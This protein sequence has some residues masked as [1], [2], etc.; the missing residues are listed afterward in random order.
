MK[1]EKEKIANKDT[2]IARLAKHIP[3]EAKLVKIIIREIKNARQK[4]RTRL[5]INEKQ[6]Q[7]HLYELIKK[8]EKSQISSL[9]NKFLAEIKIS[10]QKGEKVVLQGIFSAQVCRT[11]ARKVKN[12]QTGQPMIVPAK[13]R[14]KFRVSSRVKREI[15]SEEVKNINTHYSES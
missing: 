6:L 10:W 1:G 15:N 3:E 9:I 11:P 7:A 14:V 5:N 4:P 13:N 12:P 2:I 8:W